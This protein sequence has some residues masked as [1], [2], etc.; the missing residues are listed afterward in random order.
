MRI[1][2]VLMA[3]F[4]V[5]HFSNDVN[6]A[7]RPLRIAGNFEE[8]ETCKNVKVFLQVKNVTYRR[9]KN[10][11]T[12][13]DALLP[14]SKNLKSL[15]KIEARVTDCADGVSYNTCQYVNT[16]RF[17]SGLCRL[18]TSDSMAWSG[19]V[20]AISPPVR[21]PVLA[22]N[23]VMTNGSLNMAAVEQFAGPLFPK[24]LG[25]TVLAEVRGYDENRELFACILLKISFLRVRN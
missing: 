11:I 24:L 16:Y 17:T 2:L 21:C 18:L 8:I 9:E 22:A 19:V 10:G 6:A 7:K 14:T 1:S 23:Y 25:R 12:L 13:V 4:G 15:S 3:L 20:K 5:V